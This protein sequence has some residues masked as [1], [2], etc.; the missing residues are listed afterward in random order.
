[1]QA[2]STK[3]RQFTFVLGK[4]EV[5]AANSRGQ[6][7]DEKAE[8]I[9]QFQ[10]KLALLLLDNKINEHGRIKAAVH[11]LLWQRMTPTS[12]TLCLFVPVLLADGQ[13]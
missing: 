13:A 5:N 6:A 9:L 3:Y 11:P 8:L 2:F 12:D 1:M 7:R 10:K 4:I